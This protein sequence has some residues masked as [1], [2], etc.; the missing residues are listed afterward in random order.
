MYQYWAYGLGIHSALLMPELVAVAKVQAD[1]VVRLGE[2]E[3]PRSDRCTAGS[4]FHPSDREAFFYW[5]GLGSFLVKDGAEITID[6]PPG[7]DDRLIRLPLLGTILAVLLHQRGLMVLHGSAVAIAGEVV[8]FVGPKGRGKSTTAAML[9]GRG[10]R[11]MADDILAVSLREGHEPEVIPGFPQL[12]LWPEAAACLLGKESEYLPHLVSGY[13]KRAR[14]LGDD[15][16]RTPVRLG[17]ICVLE[18]GPAIRLIPLAP[19]DALIQL[20]ANTYVARFGRQLL[21]GQDALSHL[22]QCTSLV[23]QIPVYRFDR[24]NSLAVL[25][26]TA[27]MIE[28][29]VNSDRHVAAV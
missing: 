9:H 23:G 16:S 15:F 12:K 8:A 20:I 21:T 6:A 7:I 13:D 19:Q 10:H 5:E 28:E 22:H 2:V 11:L 29:H 18:E 4:C 1:V 27:Q 17:G 26:A 14:R 24:P 25:A 3:H